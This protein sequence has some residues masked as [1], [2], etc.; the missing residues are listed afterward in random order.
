MIILGFFA[1]VAIFAW[2]IIGVVREM[3]P[4]KDDKN[5]FNPYF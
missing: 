3:L 2:F 5:D 4:K 1:M